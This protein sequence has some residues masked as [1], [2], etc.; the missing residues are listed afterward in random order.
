MA[1]QRKKQ[2][3][4]ILIDAGKIDSNQLEEAL[5]YKQDR[6]IYLGKAIIELGLLTEKEIVQTLGDQLKLPFLELL[7][8]EIQPEVLDLIDET[9]ALKQKIMPLFVIERSLTVAISDPLNVDVI[10]D[11]SDKTG[12]EVNLVLATESDI[13]QAI[14][15]YYSA[16]QYASKTGGKTDKTARVISKEIGE[17]TEIIEAV[18]MLFDEAIKMGAS[19]I[20]IE[21]REKD[22]RIRFR[23]DGVLQQYYTVPKS[24]MAPMISRVKILANMDIAESRVPQDGRFSYEVNSRKVDVRTSTFPAVTGE[25]VVLRILDESRGRIELHKLGFSDE[26]LNKWR[27]VIRYPNGIIIVSGPTGSGKT[28]TLYATMNIVNTIEVNIMTIEDPVEY[29]LDNINQGQVNPRAG[30]TFSSALRSMLRQDPDVIMVGE[31]RDVETIEL[32]IRAALTGHLVFSTIHTNDAAS[33]FTR[34]LD[35][36]LDSFLISSSVRAILAQRLL[37]LLCPR[38]KLEIEPTEALLKSMGFEGKFKGRLFKSVGC[39]HCKNSGFHGRTGIY[40]LLIPTEEIA[41]MVNKHATATE[42]QHVAEKNGMVT[43]KNAALDIVSAGLTSV[44]EMI[45]VTIG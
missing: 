36:G 35:M 13:E 15:L 18:N 14:D 28:T 20:H 16:A 17:E 3:G 5:A 30:L 27:E 8:Y 32:A 9:M 12:M 41:D 39:A 29:N 19:D 6:N 45:R 2:L 37:R 10:D 22:V 23:V 25:K 1:V 26:T 7:N 24:S 44:E 40:E 43:L 33:S 4:Q 34:M 42:I 11:I 21:P 38:C 31:M